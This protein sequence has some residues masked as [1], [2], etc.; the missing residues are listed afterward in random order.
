MLDIVISADILFFPSA[1][2]FLFQDLLNL[3][4]VI[5]EKGLQLSWYKASYHYLFAMIRVSLLRLKIV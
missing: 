2:A 4:E 5:D 3:T 1:D